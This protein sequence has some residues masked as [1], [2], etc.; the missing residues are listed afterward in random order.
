VQVDAGTGMGFA[1]VHLM[2][3]NPHYEGPIVLRARDTPDLH[4]LEGF[5]D[6]RQLLP[7]GQ[8]WEQ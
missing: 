6:Q 1:I 2:A 3:L 5:G 4:D 8:P 7:A